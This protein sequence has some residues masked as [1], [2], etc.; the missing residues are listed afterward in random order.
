MKKILLGIF[1]IG[2]S[3]TTAFAVD[4]C[5]LTSKGGSPPYAAKCTNP[6]DSISSNEKLEVQVVV[7]RLSDKGY[8]LKSGGG[9]FSGMI[10]IRN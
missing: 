5:E 4:V 3:T 2:L 10:L 8:E 6:E 9:L 7:K 1:A